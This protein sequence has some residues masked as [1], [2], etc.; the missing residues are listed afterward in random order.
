MSGSRPLAEVVTRSTGIGVRDSP[1]CSVA[2]SPVTRSISALTSARGFEPPSWP[3]CRALR[4]SWS[5]LRVGARSS[6]TAGRGN[7]CGPVKFWPISA[8]PMTLPSV[9]DQ[10]A[11]GLLREQEPARCRSWRADRRG[12]SGRHATS[13]TMAGRIWL[14]MA[15]LLH[16]RPTAVTMR[17]ISLMPMNGTMMPPRP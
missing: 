4:T 10:A 13:I 14:S 8:E 17:S 1:P 11:I 3:R 6:P 7:I 5:V 2:T 16:A 15:G 9:Y 12:R